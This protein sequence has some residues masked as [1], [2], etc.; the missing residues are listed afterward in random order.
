MSPLD[1]A[2][3]LLAT[4]GSRNVKDS[5]TIVGRP[6]GLVSSAGK[7]APSFVNIPELIGLPADHSFADALEA[8]I[9]AASNGSL[10]RAAEELE[11]A[12]VDLVRDAAPALNIE[13][14]LYGPVPRGA[15]LI[16][17]IVTDNE[18]QQHRYRDHWDRHFYGERSVV[19]KSGNLAWIDIAR[20]A[21]MDSDLKTVSTFTHRTIA[22]IGALLAG[23]TPPNTAA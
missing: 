14:S 16:E 2:H 3:L 18:G 21:E 11:Q 12:Q 9:A 13:V 23:D 19:K 10:Q 7:W 1:A 20:P 22:T 15:I 4:V 8:L 6:G 5:A 17:E